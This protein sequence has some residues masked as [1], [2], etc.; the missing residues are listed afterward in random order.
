MNN[1]VARFD[2]ITW[3][4][5]A[6]GAREKRFQSGPNVCRLLELSTR[7]V[8]LEWCQNAHFGY[9]I[10]GQ[11][12]IEFRDQVTHYRGGDGICIHAGAASEHKA[13]VSDKVTLFLVE[14]D[15]DV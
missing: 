12:S 4:E 10:N 6:A 2:D 7:F 3:V 14:F 9:V 13:A 11:F 15:G 1:P 8:E 5:V